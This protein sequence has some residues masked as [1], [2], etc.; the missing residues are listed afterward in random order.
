MYSISLNKN[1]KDSTTT[2]AATAS[3]VHKS[4]TKSYPSRVFPNIML[5]FVALR[6][7]ASPETIL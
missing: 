5:L 3:N 4:K 7:F 2:T 6:R 1:N